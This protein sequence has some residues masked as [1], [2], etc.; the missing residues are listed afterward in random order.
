MCT[1]VSIRTC[2][3]HLAWRRV[4][5]ITLTCIF[6]PLNSFW[7]ITHVIMIVGY[8]WLLW[9]Y[10]LKQYETDRNENTSCSFASRGISLYSCNTFL[11]KCNLSGLV[12][13]PEFLNNERSSLFIRLR[14]T[15]FQHFLNPPSLI[16]VI[17]RI[18]VNASS[19]LGI[20]MW[21]WT[22]VWVHMS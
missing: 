10:I 11:T 12:E 17:S 5:T 2:L 6:R 19:W 7:T 21:V 18:F 8:D 1:C 3:V 20:L 16:F 22:V 15:C 9:I 13:N 4:G 14:F